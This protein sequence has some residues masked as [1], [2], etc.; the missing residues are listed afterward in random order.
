LPQ[1]P[2]PSPRGFAIAP[3][4]LATISTLIELAESKKAEDITVLDMRRAALLTDYFLICTGQSSRQVKAIADAVWEGCE[5][6][7][8]PILHIEGYHD[9]QWILADC[10]DV[11]AHVFTPAMRSCYGLERLW[12]DMPRLNHVAR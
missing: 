6:R 7:G 9:A 3:E 1:I 10:G 12:G 2:H 11:V 4:A 8:M 5:T